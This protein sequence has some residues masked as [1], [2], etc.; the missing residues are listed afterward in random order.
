M[1]NTTQS[2]TISF[3]KD[4]FNLINHQANLNDQ[5]PADFMRDAILDKLADRLGYQNAGQ[6]IHESHGQTVSRE[7]VKKQLGL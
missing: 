1:P 6:N 4:V 7:N 2:I 5:T 3:D